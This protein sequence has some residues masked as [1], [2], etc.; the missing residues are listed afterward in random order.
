MLQLRILSNK[1]STFLK[2]VK[3]KPQDWKASF[4]HNYVTV[5]QKNHQNVRICHQNLI[6]FFGLL[7]VSWNKI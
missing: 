3:E 7:N 5:L 4:S 6:R 1:S 2:M